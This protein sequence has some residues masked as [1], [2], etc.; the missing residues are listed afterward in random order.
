[1][2]GNLLQKFLEVDRI[3]LRKIE[4]ILLLILGEK[5]YKQAHGTWSEVKS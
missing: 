2:G 4:L 5:K 1:M 3:N